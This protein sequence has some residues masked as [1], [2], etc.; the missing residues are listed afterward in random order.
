[1]LKRAE[2]CGFLVKSLMAMATTAAHRCGP[3]GGK[4]GK[5][6]ADPGTR[7]GRGRIS[8]VAAALLRPVSLVGC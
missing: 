8:A 1:M 3:G 2:T 6:G 4:G 5:P 7:N